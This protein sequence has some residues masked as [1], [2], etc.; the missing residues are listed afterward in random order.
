MWEVIQAQQQQLQ[1]HKFIVLA[2]RQYHLW[3][4]T[5]HAAPVLLALLSINGMANTE[6]QYLEQPVRA[7]HRLLKQAQATII[8]NAELHFQPQVV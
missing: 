2:I 4:H 7:T 3:P 1:Q 6:L 5:P 8:I